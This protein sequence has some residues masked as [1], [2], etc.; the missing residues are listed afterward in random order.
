MNQFWQ[1]GRQVLVILPDTLNNII[2]LEGNIK[3]SL[4]VKQTVKTWV[5]VIQTKQLYTSSFFLTAVTVKHN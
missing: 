2:Y 4:V 3:K 1:V 5:S